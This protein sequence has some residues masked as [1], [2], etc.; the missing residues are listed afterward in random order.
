MTAD[1]TGV[2]N[3]PVYRDQVTRTL[4]AALVQ[5]R[6]TEDEYDERMGQVSALRS[7]AELAVLT[8]D[9][10]VGR[11]DAPARPPTAR[12]VRLGVSVSIAAAG[13]VAAILLWQPDDVL[14]FMTFVVAAVTLLVAPIVTVGMMVDVR[15]QNRPGGQ[16]PPGPTPAPGSLQA[17]LGD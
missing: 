2:D 13:V 10:P 1:A 5:G 3:L 14:A 4:R 9:L 17:V 12:D 16:L 8:A 6:L 11:M 15:R 7:C